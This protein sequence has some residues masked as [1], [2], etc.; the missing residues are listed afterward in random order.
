MDVAEL[1][2]SA[3]VW[4]DELRN[5]SAVLVVPTRGAATPQVL[6]AGPPAV[7]LPVA[8]RSA[9]DQLDVVAC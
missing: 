9:T 1:Q 8:E 3:L 5:H 2:S 7:V 6:G 4:K